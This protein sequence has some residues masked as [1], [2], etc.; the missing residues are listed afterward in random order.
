MVGED[1]SLQLI[2]ASAYHRIV[3]EVAEQRLDLNA[4]A[5]GGGAREARDAGAALNEALLEAGGGELQP[6]DFEQLLL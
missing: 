5:G 4:A 1:S 3:Q 6:I 2:L